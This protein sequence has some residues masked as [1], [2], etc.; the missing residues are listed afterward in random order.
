MPESSGSRT[1]WISFYEPCVTWSILPA[2]S[3]RT[4]TGV[5]PEIAKSLGWEKP[6]GAL[7][8]GVIEGG[9]ADRGGI[10]LGDIV[11]EYNGQ[12][13][14]EANDFPIM[15]ARTAVDKEIQMKVLRERKELPVTVTV[16]ELKE[17]QTPGQKEKA[18]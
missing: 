8:A 2:E 15:V 11:T 3:K 14:K 13:I 5:T 10:K 7:V 18:G 6:R 9:P 1:A 4:P 17:P 16:G 12:E